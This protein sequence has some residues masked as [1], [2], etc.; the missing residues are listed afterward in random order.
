M[1]IYKIFFATCLALAVVACGGASASSPTAMVKASILA[2]KNKD[3]EAVKK[4]LTNNSLKMLEEGAS[5]SA[6]TVD[7]FIKSGKAAPELEVSEYRNEKVEGDSASVEVKYGSEW[8]KIYLAKEGGQWKI[9]FDK[10]GLGFRQSLK[11]G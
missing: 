4:L 7:E 10:G 3:A 5:Q 9:A 1:K 6:M 8:Q 2:T 11:L